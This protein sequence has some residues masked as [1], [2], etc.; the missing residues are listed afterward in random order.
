MSNTTALNARSCPTVV[1]SVARHGI[2][3]TVI[4][5]VTNIFLFQLQQHSDHHASPT[6]SYQSLRHFDESPQLPYGYASM[7]I[8]AY[9]PFTYGD[10]GWI[11]V[12]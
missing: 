5:F 11:V 3:G 9:V 7:I 12:C 8:W 4:E 2:P 1:M 6:R 10:D